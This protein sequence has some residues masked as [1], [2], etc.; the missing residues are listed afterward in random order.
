MAIPTTADLA[1]LHLLN[2]V[3]RETLEQEIRSAERALHGMSMDG[4]NVPLTPDPRFPHPDPAIQRVALERDKETLRIGT[5]PEYSGYEKNK[6][7]QQAKQLMEEVRE[8]MPS[9][10]QMER[11]TYEN[12]ELHMRWEERNVHK[13]PALKA[14]LRILDPERDISIEMFRP[15]KPAPTNYKAYLEGFDL[16]TWTA[17]QELQA[18]LE[19]LDD[20]T[21]LEFL[22]MK[23]LGIETPKLIQRKM[24]I[25]LSTYEACVLRLENAKALMTDEEEERPTPRVPARPKK[26][27]DD[28]EA[29]DLYRVKLWLAN[30]PDEARDVRVI[31]YAI[32]IAQPRV[33]AALEKLE[34]ADGATSAA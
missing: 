16:A 27:P 14:A 15:D 33:A 26:V 12:V 28:P 20:Q 24:G 32:K 10:D 8:G 13:I 29:K 3:Q 2:P 11:A 21:Y 5:A 6:I 7:Y 9:H 22:K 4:E 30:H 18:E 31:A 19:G 25:S 34:Q 17:E 1:K 23:A